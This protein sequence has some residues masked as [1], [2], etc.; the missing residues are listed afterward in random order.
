MWRAREAA[1]IISRI[2]SDY[3]RREARVS[4][5][6]VQNL[7]KDR[8]SVVLKQDVEGQGVAGDVIEVRHGLARNKL[9]PNR[10]AVPATRP[11]IERFGRRVQSAEP[12]LH[13]RAQGTPAQ[14]M[15]AEVDAVLKHLSKVPVE[16]K[17]AVTTREKDG[18]EQLTS[19][20]AQAVTPSEVTEAVQRQRKVDLHEQLLFMDPIQE[21]GEFDVPLRMFY[22]DGSSPS[23]RLKI[24]AQGK[25]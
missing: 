14:D 16:L 19:D 21:A 22:P 7:N 20:L 13:R 9:I 2:G 5:E 24:I 4:R 8:Y 17:R 6:L 23:F 11:N 18:K 15:D 12:T 10:W 1:K 3:T 25:V